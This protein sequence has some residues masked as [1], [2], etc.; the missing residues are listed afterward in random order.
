MSKCS[1]PVA[2]QDDSNITHKSS[3]KKKKPSR[4]RRDNRND[5]WTLHLPS[6]TLRRFEHNDDRSEGLLTKPVFAHC[7]ELEK[8]RSGPTCADL[9]AFESAP[10]SMIP[11]CQTMFRIPL[12]LSTLSSLAR[13]TFLLHRPPRGL[14]QL[15]PL[16]LSSPALE[17]GEE[18]TERRTSA[19]L[20]SQVTIA[21]KKDFMPKQIQGV[22][23][24]K[25]NLSFIKEYLQ[26]TGLSVTPFRFPEK[27]G[28]RLAPAGVSTA[29]NAPNVLNAPSNGPV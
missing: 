13:D 6:L 16:P 17:K 2:S 1:V 14:L 28:V 15:P 26:E 27:N 7:F 21:K 24:Q 10:I 19:R 9:W 22:P 12:G 3:A 23:R 11:G 8:S 18:G 25:R 29:P 4:S 5:L 20:K